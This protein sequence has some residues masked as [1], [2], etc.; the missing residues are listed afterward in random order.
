MPGWALFI[1]KSLQLRSITTLVP[2]DCIGIAENEG[3]KNSVKR[4]FTYPFESFWRNSGYP[5]DSTVFTGTMVKIRSGSYWPFNLSIH[6]SI[7]TSIYLEDTYYEVD[8]LKHTKNN[9]S[10]DYW[11]VHW[12]E[13]GGIVVPFNYNFPTC[14]GKAATGCK[15]TALNT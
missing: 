15:S 8:M 12:K 1:P 7:Y 2:S 11:K 13:S 3:Y 5:I 10:C 9:Y 6:L 14:R 4:W